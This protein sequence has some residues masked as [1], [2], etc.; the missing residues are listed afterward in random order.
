MEKQGLGMVEVEA[1]DL[2]S[3]IEPRVKIENWVL[4]VEETEPLAK[5]MDKVIVGITSSCN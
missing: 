4:V 5:A 3:Q 2:K 1:P